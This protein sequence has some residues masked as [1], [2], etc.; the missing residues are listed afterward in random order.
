MPDLNVTLH[1]LTIVLLGLGAYLLSLFKAATEATV[2]TS[3]QEGV[4]AAIRELQWPAELTRELQKSRGV[5]RQ[6]LR[7]KSYGALWK[8]LRPL[9]TY[10]PT[11]IEKETVGNLFTKLTEWYFSE[12][13]GLLLTPQAR[14]FYFALQDLLRDTSYIPTE[15]RADR[16]E[17]FE[18]GARTA[19]FA[20]YVEA[21]LEAKKAKEAIS[22]LDYFTTGAFKDWD[23]DAID[24]GKK[25]RNAIKDLGADWTKLS[26]PQRFAALQQVGSKL[27]TSL[28]NDLESRL[29]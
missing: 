9:A 16:S 22:V 26:E 11:R 12:C 5:E 23:N 15:W 1:L 2:K 14:D 10:D 20:K 25:W 24:L 29:R 19:H 3:A 8:E 7:F 13:G 21:R 17:A 4:K 27:R 6:E 28:V 18:G